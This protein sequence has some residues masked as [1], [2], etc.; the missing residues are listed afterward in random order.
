MP[1]QDCLRIIGTESAEPLGGEFKRMKES[2]AMGIGI[3][4]ALD[5][6]YSR[7]PT[8][9]VRFFAIVLAFRRRRAVTSPRPCQISLLSSGH[10]R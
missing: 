3:E 4:Q 8:Q 6:M 7:V 9:E 2:L 10:G 5:K 1:L